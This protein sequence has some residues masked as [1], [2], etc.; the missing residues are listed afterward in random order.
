MKLLKNKVV[1]VDD[2]HMLIRVAYKQVIGSW[3]LT[4]R[5][6][7]K[8]HIKLWSKTS[9]CRHELMILRILI[10]KE[11]LKRR[12][13]G[14][15]KNY[16]IHSPR[17]SLYTVLSWVISN[18]NSQSKVAIPFLIKNHQRNKSTIQRRSG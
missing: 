4:V 9:F 14:Y 5:Y 6:E 17:Q 13:F 11:Q 2:F 15:N 8:L 16:L 18:T 12:G 10:F 1:L 7:F 3:P